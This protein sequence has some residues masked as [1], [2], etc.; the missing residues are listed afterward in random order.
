MILCGS[1]GKCVETNDDSVAD[2]SVNMNNDLESTSCAA[3]IKPETYDS[4][5]CQHLL[6]PYVHNSDSLL[7]YSFHP[8]ANSGFNPSPKNI[9][10]TSSTIISSVSSKSCPCSTVDMK[11]IPTEP[12]SSVDEMAEIELSVETINQ[13]RNSKKSSLDLSTGSNASELL[14]KLITIPQNADKR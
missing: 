7:S 13:N 9:A 12:F 3:T 8:N 2:G 1:R 10:S 14:D 11:K 4:N 6:K 5:K